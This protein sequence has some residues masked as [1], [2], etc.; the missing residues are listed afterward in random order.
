[1][2]RLK[3]NVVTIIIVPGNGTGASPPPPTP[4][5]P[6][7]PIFLPLDITFYHLFILDILS[8]KSVRFLIK[9]MVYI[10]P[11]NYLPFYRHN[12]HK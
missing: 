1:M 9:K 7:A 5:A 11:I 12:E 2:V 8:E 10:K 6:P 3:Q 4:L